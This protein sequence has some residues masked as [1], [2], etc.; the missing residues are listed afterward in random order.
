MGIEWAATLL[1]CVAVAFIPVPILLILYGKKIRAKSKM[2]PAPDIMLDKK[3]DEEA[4]AG[5][6]SGDSNGTD[7]PIGA[8]AEKKAA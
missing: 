2:A 3:R 6:D 8:E 1:G 4:R 5:G 7:G